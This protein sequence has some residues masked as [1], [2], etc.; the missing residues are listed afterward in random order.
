MHL[1]IATTLGYFGGDVLEVQDGGLKSSPR[2]SCNVLSS[3]SSQ[4]SLSL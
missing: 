1:L 2:I 3:N 4:V